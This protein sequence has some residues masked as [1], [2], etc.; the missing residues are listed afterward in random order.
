MRTLKAGLALSAVCLALAGGGAAADTQTILGVK[1]DL[2]NPLDPTRRAV[3]V[4]AVEGPASLDT[5]IGD[6]TVAGA[7]LRV[8]ARNATDVYDQTFDLPAAGWKK[9]F[10]LHDWPVYAGFLYSNRDVGGA[11]K[12]VIIK[13]S[14]FASPEGTPPPEVPRPGIFRIK[15]NVSARFGPIDVLPPNPGTEAGIV[16]TLGNG[17][18][19]CVGFNSADAEILANTERRFAIRKPTSEGCPTGVSTTSTTSSTSTTTSTTA[20]P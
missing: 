20:L 1:F 5:V 17:D 16:L 11:V 18:S 8:I 7:T 12:Q 9:T 10:K 15:V 13:R 14:G 6:P 4:T 19:Y 3:F 2:R